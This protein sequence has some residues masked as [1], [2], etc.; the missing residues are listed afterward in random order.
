MAHFRCSLSNSTGKLTHRNV[1]L[2]RKQMSLLPPPQ[3]G[4]LA[5]ET[6]PTQEL[7]YNY[8]CNPT[9]MP[10]GRFVFSA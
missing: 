10:G 5:L 8:V 2:C 3:R 6:I 9:Q 1:D 7:T 4:L